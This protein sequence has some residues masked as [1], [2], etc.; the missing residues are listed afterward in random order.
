MEVKMTNAELV[1]SVATMQFVRGVNGEAAYEKNE[2]KSCLKKRFKIFQE[3]F[4]EKTLEH[5]VKDDK[6]NPVFTISETKKAGSQYA[7]AGVGIDVP[8]YDVIEGHEE[9]LK[10]AHDTLRDMEI[11]VVVRGIPREM[12]PLFKILDG[13]P[14]SLDTDEIWSRFLE[15][16]DAS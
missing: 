15:P 12:R 10:G 1:Q 4:L 13:A 8:M 16:N 6:G 7:A 5:A 11:T 3:T 2:V 9:E 14:V